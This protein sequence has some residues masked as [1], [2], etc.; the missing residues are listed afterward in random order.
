MWEDTLLVLLP[1]WGVSV[2]EGRLQVYWMNKDKVSHDTRDGRVPAELRSHPTHLLVFMTSAEVAAAQFHQNSS[3]PV[4]V[5]VCACVRA[6]MRACIAQ[7]RSDLHRA[8][9]NI[10]VKEGL[11]YERVTAGCRSYAPPIVGPPFAPAGLRSTC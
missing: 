6:C 4:C 8:A 9:L 3:Y 11:L 2:D 10:L 5:C 7:A 1:S